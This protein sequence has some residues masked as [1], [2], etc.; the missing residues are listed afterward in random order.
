MAKSTSK[1]FQSEE[2]KEM[3]E[4]ALNL[5][6]EEVKEETLSDTPLHAL[7]KQ[8]ADEVADSIVNNA[9]DDIQD[10]DLTVTRKKRFRIN[11]DN[12]KILELNTSDLGIS[13]RLSTA[14]ERLT[15]Y[16]DE[17]SKIV[18]ALP[19]EG[20][21]VTDSDRRLLDEQLDAVDKK[22]R[23]ELDFIFDAP[24]SDI[25]AD[26]GAMY[27]P[28]EGAFRFEHIIEALLKLYENNLVSEFSKMKRRVNNRTSK[29]T[30][31]YHN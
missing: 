3:K 11:G 5:P 27:D 30:K 18:S 26:G 9:A 22:M 1:L 16:I 13:S 7:V 4:D 2:P 29:Y 20:E 10:I 23:Q 8:S 14:Y 17:V 25:C 12:N 28:F 24:V 21:E 19:D 15:K 31:K 6:E